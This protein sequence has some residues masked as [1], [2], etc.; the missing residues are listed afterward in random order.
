MSDLIVA[1]VNVIA[2]ELPTASEVMIVV[3]PRTDHTGGS[4][5]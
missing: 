3:S 1:G 5:A 4:P 2:D